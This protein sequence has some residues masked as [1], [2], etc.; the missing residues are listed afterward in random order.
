VSTLIIQSCSAAQDQ[1]WFTS[2]LGSVEAWA[3]RAGHHYRFVGDELFDLV[4]AWYLEKT[5][6]KLPVA[7]DYARL[8]LLQQALTEGYDE[9]VWFDADVVIFDRNLSL[10]FT[11][12]CAFGQEVWVQERAGKLQAR[13]NV[14]NAVCVFRQG[15]PVLPFLIHTVSSLLRRVDPAHIAPQLVGPKLLNALHPLCDFALLPQVGALSP[16]VVRDLGAGSGPALDLLRHESPVPLSAVNVCASLTG[17]TA[18]V[19]AVNALL[20]AGRL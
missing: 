2:C 20:A 9:A 17:G 4:P 15:C 5:R 19:Q 10:D 16:E 8:V 18:A 12:S 1:S 6:D 13:R 3:E 7:V 11:G 14:H